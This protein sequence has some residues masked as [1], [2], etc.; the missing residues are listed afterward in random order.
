VAVQAAVE[1]EAGRHADDRFWV[2]EP[3]L[4]AP[5]DDVRP[6]DERETRAL[7]RGGVLG[8]LEHLGTRRCAIALHVDLAV[9]DELFA[10]IVL[11][12]ASKMATSSLYARVERDDAGLP[13]L[14]PW[15]T[16]PEIE[17]EVVAAVRRKAV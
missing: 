17:D 11:V 16:A 3:S 4:V 13:A 2:L 9:D 1:A 15:T 12:A 8:L 6:L 7:V 10:A 5:P 14:D